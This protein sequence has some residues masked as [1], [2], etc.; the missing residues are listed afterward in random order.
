M[1]EHLSF[2]EQAHPLLIHLHYGSI[3]S[4]FVGVNHLILVHG[5]LSRVALGILS[6]VAL[7]FCHLLNG[8]LSP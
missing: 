6:P 7:A 8:I 2:Q 3:Q 4:H 1:L 5:V